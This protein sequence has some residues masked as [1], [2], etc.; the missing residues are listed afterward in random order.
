MKRLIAFLLLVLLIGSIIGFMTPA[1]SHNN[2]VVGS[3]LKLMTP[4][5]A[6]ADSDTVS[7][8]TLPKPPPIK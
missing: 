7:A 5:V 4:S 6:Y 1:N 2:E 8:P 3:V